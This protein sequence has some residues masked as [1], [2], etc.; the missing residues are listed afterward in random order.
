MRSISIVY[1][2][3]L[4][5]GLSPLPAVAQTKD[6]Q[7]Q[8]HMYA[9]ELFGDDLTDTEVSG[10]VPEL[11]DDLVVGLR[12]GYYFTKSWGLEGSLGFSPNTANGVAGA[13]GGEV[14]LDVYYLDVN[15]VW[16]F[17]PNSK[18]VG[19]LTGGAGIAQAD[20][21]KPILGVVGGRSV[22]IDDDSG[23]TLNAGVGLSY[24]ATDH[25]IVR[26]DGRYRYVDALVDHLDNSLNTFEGSVGLGWAF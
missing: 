10:E 7:S 16:N 25:L 3:A 11:D 1:A 6:G 14:D 21:D 12:Y 2:A 19:Y 20:L 8:V 23:F 9:G 5:L 22:A 13:R 26:L 4:V 18:A 17:T 15:A 24:F